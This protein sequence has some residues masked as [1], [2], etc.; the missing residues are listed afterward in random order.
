MFFLYLC[1]NNLQKSLTKGYHVCKVIVVLHIYHVSDKQGPSANKNNS[2]ARIK[3]WVV[4]LLPSACLIMN[5]NTSVCVPFCF[6]KNS[7]WFFFPAFAD[8]TVSS[9]PNGLID[10]GTDVELQC[11]ARSS[12]FLVTRVQWMRKNSVL[13]ENTMFTLRAVTKDDTEHIAVLL[14]MKMG[15]LIQ[16]ICGLISYVSVSKL[17]GIKWRS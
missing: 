7:V 2:L 6:M 11:L 15:R 9:N 1:K 16:R 14:L 4:Y 8:I 5:L 12:P 17:D 10:K 13:A 3:F